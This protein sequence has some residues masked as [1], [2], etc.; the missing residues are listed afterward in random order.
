MKIVN[1]KPKILIVI[2]VSAFRL[3]NIQKSLIDCYKLHIRDY[4]IHYVNLFVPDGLKIC[5]QFGWDY[6]IF[7][8]SFLSLRF[9]RKRFLSLVNENSQWFHN[10]NA[11][12]K[13][14][15]IQDEFVHMDLVCDFIN[16]YGVTH[17]FSVAPE[18]EFAKLY[19]TVDL[20]RVRFHRV[21]TGYI[22]YQKVSLVEKSE[23]SANHKSFL[24]GYRVVS[25]PQWGSFN[26]KKREIADV[27]VN[28]CNK[29]GYRHDIKIGEQYFLN[30][31]AWVLH[32]K[33]CRATIGVEG[34]ANILDWDGS[35]S[36]MIRGVLTSGKEIQLED[37]VRLEYDLPK[38]NLKALSPRHL[39]ACMTRTCQILIEGEY[40]N[41][42]KP[43]VH[44][45]PLKSDYS[46]INE[47]FSA[48]EDDEL[49]KKITDNAFNEIVNSRLYGY[50]MFAKFVVNSLEVMTL[51]EAPL[52][53]VT[54]IMQP[55]PKFQ[56]LK[57]ELFNSMSIFKALVY[58][59]FKLMI[60]R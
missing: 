1:N 12:S 15:T 48:L 8:S 44:Y 60:S 7:H 50:D 21:L 31:D 34:G 9:N 40:N 59:M 49:V 33:K 45:I 41:V 3:R 13:A 26:F 27:F 25:T 53:F 4:D 10:L 52:N 24:V 54:Q 58:Y 14:L 39:E 36:E 22:D 17:V 23:D 47:V 11:R 28:E 38:I 29:R 2:Y 35:F 42:L 37:L 46:N 56:S 43:W 6:V 19:P 16:Q 30:G 20:L 18:S 55:I 32:L 57:V 5:A 51:K